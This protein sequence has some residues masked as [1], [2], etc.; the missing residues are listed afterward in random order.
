MKEHEWAETDVAENEEENANHTC[1]NLS[2]R[3]GKYQRDEREKW[4]K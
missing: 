3:I 1:N 2:K 4:L